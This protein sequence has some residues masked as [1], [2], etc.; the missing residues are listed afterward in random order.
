MVEG[1][2]LRNKYEKLM[3]ESVKNDIKA[4]KP[5]GAGGGTATGGGTIM[6][7]PTMRRGGP[8]GGPEGPVIPGRVVE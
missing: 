8:M 7:P 4:G 5:V 1:S 3:P 2:F 6:G